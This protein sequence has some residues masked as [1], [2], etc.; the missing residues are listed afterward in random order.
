M[1]KEISCAIGICSIVGFLAGGCVATVQP[2]PVYAE[3]TY[4]PAYI[5]TYPYVVYEGRPV[6]YVEGYWYVRRGPG[7][8]YYRKEPP[9]LY[10]QRAYVQP[11]P[12]AP[13]RR[14][15]PPPER[16]HSSP[17]EH[18]YAS[19]PVQSAPPATRVR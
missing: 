6:Y 8:A 16:H 10:R 12:R 19:P 2:D 11:A 17:P 5:E 14:Y 3:A 15:A 4:V 9:Y 7:W 1:R 13:E 18:H